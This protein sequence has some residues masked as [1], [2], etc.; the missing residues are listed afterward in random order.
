MLKAFAT[1]SGLVGLAASAP[2]PQEVP[3][4][5]QHQ[6][7]VAQ[8]AAAVANLQQLEAALAGPTLPQVP[9]LA[10]HQ[11][12]EQQ[13]EAQIRASDPARFYANTDAERDLINQQ[14]QHAARHQITGLVGASGN[15]GPSGLCGPSGCVAF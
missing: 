4:L 8:H 3:G 6:A 5:A 14:V 11:A 7:A 10:E 13:L 1:L 2:M 12:A 9:G 15:I